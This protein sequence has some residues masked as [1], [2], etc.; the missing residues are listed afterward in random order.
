MTP[1]GY[2]KVFT[3]NLFFKFV[4]DPNKRGSNFKWKDFPNKASE[5]IRI[6]YPWTNATAEQ[7][8]LAASVAFKEAEILIKS[9][10]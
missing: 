1:D 10:E 4:N 6:N 2:G 5:L 9:L 8:E 3:K 7:K